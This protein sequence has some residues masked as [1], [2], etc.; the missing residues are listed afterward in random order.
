MKILM[1]C[2]GDWGGSAW[3][4]A[5]AINDLG[6]HEAHVISFTDAYTKYPVDIWR[7]SPAEIG[8]WIGWADVVNVHDDADTMIPMGVEWK[9]TLQSFR[10]TWFRQRPGHIME[11]ARRHNYLTHCMTPDLS[12]H[13]PTWS[14]KAVPDLSGMLAQDEVFRVIHAPTKRGIRGTDAII[15]ACKD[16]EGVELDLIEGVSNEECLKRKAKGRLLIDQTTYGKGVGAGTGFCG[17]ALEA[18]SMGMPVISHATSE[19][20]EVY[21][22]LC[23][24]LP[25]I[26]AREDLREQII[27]LRDNPDL[28]AKWAQKGH[29]YWERLHKPDVAAARFIELCEKALANGKPRV[30]TVSVTMIV[31]NEEEVLAKA[32]ASTNGLA[33]EVVVYD[34]GSEDKTV[35]LAREMGAKVITGGDRMDKGG[36][37][38]AAIKAATGDWVVVLDADETIQD[39]AKLRYHLQVSYADGLMV[40]LVQAKKGSQALSYHQQRVWLPGQ[41]WYKYRAHE[42]PLPAEGKK[43]LW[44]EQTDYV[45]LH[46]QPAKR[47][48][49]K[50]D[51]TL[52]RLLLDVKEHPKASRPVYYL[53]RQYRY[54]ASLPKYAEKKAEYNAKSQTMLEHYLKLTEKEDAWDRPNACHDLAIMYEEQ[55]EQQKRMHT[56]LLACESQPMNRRWWAELARAHFENGN[57]SIGMGLMKAALEIKKAEE[58]GYSLDVMHQAYPYE[59]LAQWCWMT[60]RYPEGY[61]YIKEALAWAPTNER[62]QNNI[63][64]FRQKLN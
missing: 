18:W 28:C 47:W 57:R 54:M 11:R 26:R 23:G 6:Q 15:E 14:P 19:I 42:L 38:N 33:D 34:T 12:L 7:P 52:E 39:P 64:Q 59:M 10:G 43:G 51:Y 4:M 1:L 27:S 32:I 48:E 22:R 8:K 5:K 50:V 55:G 2:N 20:Q 3:Q 62:L 29:D 36:S 25:F 49:W 60:K 63:E 56:L 21:E 44:I 17:N 45:W 24:E 53:A 35:E 58:D 16:L 13:G 9:P 30:Q 46:E 31:R 40:R 61:E 41:F 37:R